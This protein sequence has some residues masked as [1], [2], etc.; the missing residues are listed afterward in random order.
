MTACQGQRRHGT[1]PELL[2]QDSDR[3]L[4][5]VRRFFSF[6]NPVNETSARLVATGVVV[7]AVLFVVIRSG[8]LLVPLV[9][10]F[11]ARVLTGPTMSPLGQL[12]T[13]V[14]TSRLP[15]EDRFVS[16]PPKRFAQGM[17]L[18]FSAAAGIAWLTGTE[19]LAFVL[20]GFLVG[21]A[22]LEAGLGLCLGCKAFALLMRA[23]IVPE[24]V[25][26][27]CGDVTGRLL[28]ASAAQR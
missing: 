20:I 8:W 2:S 1:I 9:Y 24:S 22:V 11:V 3:T 15:F 6:P 21:A 25:C 18:V 7:Q 27:E 14:L 28:A 10:G 16:G 12:A 13:R 19:W 17:G 26:A 23:G 4:T 5:V